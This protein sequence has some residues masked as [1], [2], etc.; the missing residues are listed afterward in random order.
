MSADI[1]ELPNLEVA[2]RRLQIAQ[3]RAEL[4]AQS[5][6]ERQALGERKPK[7]NLAKFG[8]ARRKQGGHPGRPPTPTFGEHILT[9]DTAGGK[10]WRHPV[11]AY[12]AALGS[13]VLEWLL[14]RNDIELRR[15]PPFGPY[16]GGRY[17][18]D[19]LLKRAIIETST[20]IFCRNGRAGL[21]PPEWLPQAVR[22]AVYR[23][24]SKRA[25]S[26]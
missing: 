1:V 21:G 4:K 20:I 22:L 13:L 14:R 3:R 17:M 24:P 23:R 8:S 10:Q 7:P 11:W 2:T 16:L 9:I 6:A 26:P 18:T 15:S 12:R 19:R 5:E 25:R